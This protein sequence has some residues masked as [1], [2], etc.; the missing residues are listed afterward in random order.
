MPVPLPL[1]AVPPAGKPSIEPSTP[2]P[3]RPAT[4]RAGCLD[5]A[6]AVAAPA[7][8]KV[9]AFNTPPA[10]AIR[11][12]TPVAPPTVQASRRRRGRAADAAPKVCR[13]FRTRSDDE[14]ADTPL[15][16]WR[17]RPRRDRSASNA[18][19]RALCGYVLDPA[20]TGAIG[21]IAADQHEAEGVPARRRNGPAASI[22]REQRQHL[23]RDD[24]H[25]GSE[26]AAGRSL[27]ARPVSSAPAMLWSRI[28]AQAGEADHLAAGTGATAVVAMAVVASRT[29]FL[30]SARHGAL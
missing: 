25:E 30:T 12:A 5:N 28:G 19:G 4:V 26:C 21:E 17:P 27:R 23:L 7:Q 29:C 16:D 3:P 13:R 11:D 22:S 9:Q 8:P 6:G 10:I 20:S 18:C 2:A 14:P 24:R 1:P 15:G